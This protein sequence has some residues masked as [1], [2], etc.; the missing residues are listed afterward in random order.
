M[1]ANGKC[2]IFSAPSGAGKTTIVH[3]LLNVGIGLEFSVS[4]CSRDP[5]PNEVDGKDYHFLGIDGFKKQIDAGAFV[6]WEEVFTNNYYGTLKSEVERIW[7]NGKAVIFDVDVIGGLNLK[8][9][10]GAD[11]LAIFVQPPSYEELEKRLR[12]R[13][14]ETED[15]IQQRM[16][17]ASKELSTASEFDSIL[18]NADLDKAIENAKNLVT[19]FIQG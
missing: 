6:E 3:A 10:F 13:S 2:I 14:T 1:S 4:A 12:Y 5:R 19:Q 17:K 9:I 16:A 7:E 11:A 18:V 8:K 15:K